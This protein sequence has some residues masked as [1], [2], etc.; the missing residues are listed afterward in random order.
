MTI[1]ELTK[2][3]T[4]LLTDNE[5][6]HAEIALLKTKYISLFAATR[7]SFEIA[8]IEFDLDAT[9]LNQ[10][11]DEAAATEDTFATQEQIGRDEQ[12][13]D[14]GPTV[15]KNTGEVATF[16]TGIEISR[17]R[18][19]SWPKNFVRPGLHAGLAAS[20]TLLSYQMFQAIFAVGNTLSQVETYL[21]NP[22]L[23]ELDQVDGN[24]KPARRK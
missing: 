2:V 23:V 12:E 16:S 22:S 5:K 24:P 9:Y 3:L 14:L 18:P 15:T 6:H 4:D 1:E 7:R 13:I 21:A 19:A 10:L 17:Q 11:L 20:A 8:K